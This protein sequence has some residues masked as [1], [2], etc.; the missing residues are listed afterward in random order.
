MLQQSTTG[1]MT[2][3]ASVKA[4]E[5]IAEACPAEVQTKRRKKVASSRVTKKARV[6][7]VLLPPV[8]TGP[9]ASS[10]TGPLP[11]SNVDAASHQSAPTRS[12]VRTIFH[13]M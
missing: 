9:T 1:K 2:R 13:F 4:S 12:K 5:L 8:T 10:S 7:P 6:D 11:T 3:I